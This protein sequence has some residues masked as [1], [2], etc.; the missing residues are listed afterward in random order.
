MI[1]VN[2]ESDEIY[3]ENYGE[4]N[5]GEFFFTHTVT[6][7]ATNSYSITSVILILKES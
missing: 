1:N 6:D 3:K 7:D 4:T 2:G 5:E